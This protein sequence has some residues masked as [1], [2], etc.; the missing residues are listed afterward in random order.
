MDGRCVSVCM[1]VCMDVCMYKW[2]LPFVIEFNKGMIVCS[3]LGSQ[4][5]I[6]VVAEGMK[7]KNQ[8]HC[9]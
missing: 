9:T 6:L 2:I 4:T 3:V 1:D 5:G 8:T 7:N